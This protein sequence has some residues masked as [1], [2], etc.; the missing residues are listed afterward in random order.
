MGRP[1]PVYGEDRSGQYPGR[2]SGRHR[3]QSR[4]YLSK[5]VLADGRAGRLGLGSI[6]E[7]RPWLDL[8]FC[9]GWLRPRV[10]PSIGQWSQAGL[11]AV[12]NL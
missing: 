9:C 10:Q 12:C 3:H 5:I 8:G 7:R 2:R 11:A 6:S 4:R 1:E